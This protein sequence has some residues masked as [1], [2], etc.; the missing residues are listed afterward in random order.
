RHVAA[1]V[2]GDV[3]DDRQAESGAAGRSRASRVDPVE[4]LEDSL[5]VSDGDA[6]SLVG[7]CQLDAVTVDRA[8]G[9]DDRRAG[10]RVGDGVADEVADRCDEKLVVAPDV[11]VLGGYKSDLNVLV[12]GG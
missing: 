9:D 2:G 1:V 6:V 8:D 3:L 11:A 10:V 12:L 4:P 5:L 7:Y